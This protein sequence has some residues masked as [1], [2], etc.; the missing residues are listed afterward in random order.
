[1]LA[2]TALLRE[3]LART[4]DAHAAPRKLGG[5]RGRSGPSLVELALTQHCNAACDHCYAAPSLRSNPSEL[6]TSEVLRALDELRE[7]GV[8]TLVLSGGEPLLRSD[9]IPVVEE[10]ST[11][12]ME[13]RLLTNGLLLNDALAA[14]LARAGL[15]YV[16]VNIDGGRERAGKA[17]AD[18]ALRSA[19]DVLKVVVRAGIPAGL[20]VRLTPEHADVLEDR[21]QL[22]RDGGATR[23]HASHLVYVGTA[24]R[25]AANQP[26]RSERRATVAA[27]FGLAERHLGERKAPAVVTDGNESDGP[28]LLRYVE[29]RHGAEAAHVIERRLA[30]SGGN[31]AGEDTLAI[32]ARGRVHPSPFWQHAVLGDLRKQPFAEAL[33]HPLREE[34]QRRA[35]RLEGRCGGCRYLALCRGGHRER[36]LATH[37]SLWAED[38]DCLLDDEEI[39]GQDAAPREVTTPAPA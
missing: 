22:A 30:Q 18:D 27:L 29:T 14:R 31:L 39:A 34:L 32:D 25:Q 2:V 17:E 36:A 15:S 6:T 28:L 20:H 33:A 26:A 9:L 21:Y 37:G 1:M 11:L 7:G 8:R 23:F 24:R 35:A 5:K 19:R 10:A 12:G 3:A 38:P 13:V 16:G 4:T